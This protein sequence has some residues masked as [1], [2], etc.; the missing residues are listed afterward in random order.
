MEGHLPRTGRAVLSWS[1]CQ[2]K[3]LH[4][5]HPK[6]P[7]LNWTQWHS[8]FSSIP[9]CLCSFQVTLDF[10]NWPPAHLTQ[11]LHKWL[12]HTKATGACTIF[13][14]SSGMLPCRASMSWS[15]VDSTR[16]HRRWWWLFC[17]LP[18][19]SCCQMTQ[20][21]SGSLLLGSGWCKAK[22]QRHVQGRWKLFQSQ[23]I[24]R[25]EYYSLASHSQCD[26]IRTSSQGGGAFFPNRIDP[27]LSGL[28]TTYR[29]Y[30]S[31]IWYYHDSKHYFFKNVFR[32]MLI[33]HFIFILFIYLFFWLHH[34]ACGILVPQPGTELTPLEA[35]VQIRSHWPTHH[36][37]SPRACLFKEPF[38]LVIPL[39]RPRG[40]E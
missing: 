14:R 11:A 16:A 9:R 20:N 24:H 37:G 3:T 38:D 17:W 23:K 34:S 21:P 18:W 15:P 25:L 27:Y 33:L 31:I 32:M 19:W 12:V 13:L 1:L 36:Q 4:Q 26:G 35:E 2:R 22:G 39:L 29:V 40:S 7:Q 28:P 5:Q 10:R 6:H 8:R 30:P